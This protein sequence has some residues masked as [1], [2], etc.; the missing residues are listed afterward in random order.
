MPWRDRSAP[1]SSPYP[2]D[3]SPC[4]PGCPCLGSC[5]EGS[6]KVAGECRGR[7]CGVA[8]VFVGG[9]G[10]GGGGDIVVALC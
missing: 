4:H 6:G 10:G 5:W 8:A 2:G 7:G 3:T 9:G 1:P